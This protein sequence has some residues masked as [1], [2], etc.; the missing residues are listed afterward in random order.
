MN[1]ASWIA[2][3]GIYAKSASPLIDIAV[4]NIWAYV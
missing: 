4:A 2:S 3:K 1:G